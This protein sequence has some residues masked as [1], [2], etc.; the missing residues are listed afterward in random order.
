MAN[1]RRIEL[2]VG[3]GGSRESSA[4]ICVLELHLDN[5]GPHS[6]EGVQH[7][8]IKVPGPLLLH[9]LEAFINGK[10]FFVEALPA[11]CIGIW[12]WMTAYAFEIDKPADYFRY[13]A[14]PINATAATQWQLEQSLGW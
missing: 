13:A 8:G 11:E 14:W 10:C 1:D 3:T 7:F 12:L 2:S 9:D 4:L 6:D 5:G